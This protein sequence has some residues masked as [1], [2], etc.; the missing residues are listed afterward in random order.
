MSEQAESAIADI[1]VI[2]EQSKQVAAAFRE[3]EQILLEANKAMT[4]FSATLYF[5]IQSLEDQPA[6]DP[7]DCQSANRMVAL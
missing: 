1:Q 4:Q 2:I 7:A 5:A 3:L 6:P